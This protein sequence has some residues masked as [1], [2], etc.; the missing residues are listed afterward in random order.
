MAKKNTHPGRPLATLAV[1]IVIGIVALIIGH[2][3]QGAAFHP[4][5]ALD[6]EGGTQVIL[7]PR[8]QDGADDKAI[9]AEDMN[10]AIRIIRQRVDASGVAE[11]EISTLGSNNIVV[12]IPG[13]ADED[14][15]NLVRSS[16]TMRFRP[17]LQVGDPGALDPAQLLEQQSGLQSGEEAELLSLE[18]A[19]MALADVDGDGELSDSPLTEPENSS[20]TAW[21]TEQVVYDYLVLDCTDPEALTQHDLDDSA[22]PLVACS[23]DG[24]S[25]YILGPVDVEGVNLSKATAGAA[26]T[27][28]GQA[29]GQYAVSLELNSEGTK[30]FAEA[31][32]RLYEFKDTDQVRNRFGVVLDGNVIIAPSMNQPIADGKAEITGNFSASEAQSLANQLQFGSLPLN[33]EVQSEQ[34]ISATLGSNHLEKGLWAGL[35]GLVLVVLYMIWQY[36]GLALLS[37]GSLVVAGGLTYL[38]ITILSW[39]MGYRLSLPGVAG[40]VVAVGITADS[41]IVYFERIRDEVREG[42]PLVSAVEDGWS[43]ARRTIIISDAVNLLAAIVLYVL[44]VGGVQGFAFTLG[45][46]TV[47]DL[48][49]VIFFT[50]PMLSLMIRTPFFGGGHRLSGLDPSHLGAESSITYQGRGKFKEPNGGAKVKAKAGERQLALAAVGASTSANTAGAGHPTA[51]TASLDDSG[52]EK[53]P[54]A[55]RRRLAR[56]AQQETQTK[57]TTDET[58]SAMAFSD[59]VVEEQDVAAAVEDSVVEDS[60]ESA[61]VDVEL[62]DEL[63]DSEDKRG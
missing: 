56:L 13:D 34:Q 24:T 26:Y 54:L 10:E 7:T 23:A 19:A 46:T 35:I 63:S 58:D 18:E 50:H 37:A 17:V 1:A 61:A 6:L 36:R 15:L 42:R 38:I 12:A 16:A 28:T 55:E 20:D 40:L 51:S 14:I 44:A 11:A 25:K 52:G 47:V 62:E 2:F 27:S 9:S 5:L 32:S 4:K 48:I 8:L 53:L 29:T 41:F 43:R 33:F 31:S 60:D 57:P 22:E 59:E 49:V 3:A 21:L 39:T 30:Q 45:V